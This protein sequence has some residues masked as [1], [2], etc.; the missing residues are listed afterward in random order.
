MEEDEDEDRGEE[1]WHKL[2]RKGENI[3]EVGEREV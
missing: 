3:E 2:R 1:E